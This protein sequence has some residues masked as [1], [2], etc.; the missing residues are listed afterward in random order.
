MK[1]QWSSFLAGGSPISHSFT[2]WAKKLLLLACL[3]LFGLQGFAAD[4][5]VSARDLQGIPKRHKYLTSII[6]GAAI[7][8]GI[9]ILAPGGNRSMVKGLLVGGSG[10]S[11]LYLWSHRNAAG[12]WT[13]WAHVA[14]NT[15]LASGVG[16]T[17]CDCSAGAGIGALL[18]GGGTLAVQAFGTR[19]PRIARA[20]GTQPQN[21]PP[22]Q[23]P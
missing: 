14:S 6:A 20:A 1:A 3:G 22:Q 16:W 21:P 2:S 8:A 18:G 23:K 10:A 5:S 15:G 11:T 12:A 7:G 4:P 19:D 17:I 9:G 13:P